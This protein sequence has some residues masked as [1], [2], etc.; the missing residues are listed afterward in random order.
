MEAVSQLCY[1]AIAGVFCPNAGTVDLKG[2]QF[3]CF[4][5]DWD[6]KATLSGRKNIFI[7]GIFAWIYRKTDKEKNRRLLNLPNWGIH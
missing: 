5:W 2:I 6:L 3:H 4:R 1:E 7:S